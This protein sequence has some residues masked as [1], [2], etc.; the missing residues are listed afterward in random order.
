ME[1][2][3]RI[4]IGQDG[5]CAV[6]DDDTELSQLENR[7]E[8]LYF[9]G[10]NADARVLHAGQEVVRVHDYVHERVDDGNVDCH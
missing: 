4:T 1:E 8:W 9:V 3:A 6:C 2:I 5:N 10:D 7:Y